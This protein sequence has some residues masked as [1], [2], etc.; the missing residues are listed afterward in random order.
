LDRKDYSKNYD[1]ENVRWVDWTT[2]MN[3]VSSNIIVQIDGR[4]QTLTQWGRELGLSLAA[5][6]NRVHKGWS[7]ERALTTP[8]KSEA[9]GN[10]NRK[11]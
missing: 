11:L 6:R 2:Q 5:V 7:P 1:P 8:I 3:N 10:R 9:G 4:T